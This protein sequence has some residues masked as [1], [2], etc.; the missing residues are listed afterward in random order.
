M[1]Y[2]VSLNVQTFQEK[3]TYTNCGIWSHGVMVSTQDFESCDPSSNLS[4]TFFL[5]FTYIGSLHNVT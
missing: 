4:G 3:M 5:P 1:Q 2:S